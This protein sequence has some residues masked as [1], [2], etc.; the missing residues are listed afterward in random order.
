MSR[1]P[2]SPPVPVAV[3]RRKSPPKRGP[4]STIESVNPATEAVL[5]R[6]ETHTAA[7]VEAALAKADAAFARWRDVP[8][9][10]RA[11]PMRAL[12]KLLRERKDKYARF[13]TLEMGKPIGEAVAEIE[14][15]AWNCD[16]YA[17]HA[18]EF[19]KDEPVATNARES[20]VAFEPLGA[21]LAAMPWNS[22]CC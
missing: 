15:C 21:I 1:S 14:K 9:R 13:I 19:L 22:P 20:F 5:A 18:E 10:D 11:V 2:T 4:M 16:F 17:E 6:F 12:A 8:I 3:A 7:D